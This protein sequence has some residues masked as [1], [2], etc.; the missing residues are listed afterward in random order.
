MNPI[1]SPFSL[2]KDISYDVLSWNLHGTEP[3]SRPQSEA[4]AGALTWDPFH[5]TG[6]L[7]ITH[8]PPCQSFSPLGVAKDENNMENDPRNFLFESYVR[9]LN[10][11]LPQVFVF[12]NVTGILKAVVNKKRIFSLVARELSIN[13]RIVTDPDIQIL[14]NVILLN[15]R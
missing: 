14:Q 9:I 15:M 10:E 4:K 5:A 7:Q 2:G 11:F 13:Y 6:R 1:I 12:E 8:S 3:M